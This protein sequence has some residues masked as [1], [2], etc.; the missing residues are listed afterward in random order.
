M[1][2]IS[3]VAAK[4][5]KL[6]VAVDFEDLI[7][8]G[9]FAVVETFDHYKSGPE[10]MK[11]TTY[12]WC[13]LQKAFAKICS[14]KDR[15]AVIAYANGENAVMSYQKF[16]KAKKKLPPGAQHTVISRFV[17][18]EELENQADVDFNE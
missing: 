15:L 16:Q 6:D 9:Y 10:S 5:A 8:Q 2:I 13:Q 17:S 3:K 14:A 1:P 18:Y 4:Y 7:N 12:L 11:I